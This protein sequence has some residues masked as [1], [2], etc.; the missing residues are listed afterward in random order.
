MTE[1]LPPTRGCEPFAPEL[2]LALDASTPMATVALLRGT[3]LVA[4]RSTSSRRG[5]G[6]RLLSDASAL[7]DS[8][9]LGVADLGLIAVGVGP[10]SFT[11]IRIA[12]ATARALAWATGVPVTGVVSL[13]ALACVAAPAGSLV[14][15]ALDARK[16]EVYGALYRSRGLDA[17]PAP[18]LQPMVAAPAELRAAVDAA[19][20][21]ET[22]LW[23]GDGVRVYPGH[24]GAPAGLIEGSLLLDALRGGAVATLGR[25]EVQERGACTLA[26][27]LPIYL[28]RSEAELNIGPPTG[29]SVLLSR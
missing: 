7:L 15:V 5:A 21:G 3:A 19:S 23:I 26:E 25:L 10:G 6:G 28:R 8:Q 22:S 20:D 9:G 16:G 13:E 1:P 4:E 14:A 2:T 27:L 17:R 12:M 29:A 24:L 18:V 11:G